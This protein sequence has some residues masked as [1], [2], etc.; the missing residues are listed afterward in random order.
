MRSERFTARHVMKNAAATDGGR[1][2][3]ARSNQACTTLAL[4]AAHTRLQLMPGDGAHMYRYVRVSG[5]R[6]AV[7]LVA[8]L[9]IMAVNESSL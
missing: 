7:T 6:A 2:R 9:V 8:H 4:V 5:W 1:Q 3:L